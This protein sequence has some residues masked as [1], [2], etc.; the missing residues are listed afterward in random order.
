M[1]LERFVDAPQEL[2]T[3]LVPQVSLSD[4]MSIDRRVEQ[5]RLHPELCGG[6]ASRPFLQTVDESRHGHRQRRR[7]GDRRHLGL[8]LG[9]YLYTQSRTFGD[10]RRCVR[11]HPATSFLS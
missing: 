11:A 8:K 7:I 6:R 3:L 1:T 2:E 4:L 9:W 5:G 10:G